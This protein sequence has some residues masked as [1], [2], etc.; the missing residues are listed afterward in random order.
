[1]THNQPSQRE[2]DL[3]A[4]AHRVLPGGNLGNP[5]SDLLIERGE[6]SRVWDV[7]GNEYIDYLLGS[8]PMIVGHSH[9]EV[10]A[11]VREQLE[12]G[13]TF[14]AGNEHAVALAEEIVRAV[15]CAEK[16]RFTS[17]GTEATLYAMRAARAFTGRDKILK[18]EGGFHGMNE[19]ALMS[20][21]PSDPPA[22]PQAAADSAGIPRSI[23]DEVLIAPFNDL[24]TTS[25]IIERH[26]DELGGVIVEPVQR[27]LPPKAGFLEG[28]REV[29]EHHRIPLIFDEIVTGFRMSYGGAQEYFGVTP[30][31]CTLGKAAAGGFP[32]AVVAGKDDIMSHMDPEAVSSDG[33]MPQVGTLSGNPI[34]AVA[35]LKTL[36][37]LR[38]EGTYE[39]LYITGQRTMDALQRLLDQAEIPARVMGNATFFDVYFTDSEVTDYR[40]I[41]QADGSKLAQFNAA[42]RSAGVIKGSPKFYVSTVHT[43]EDLSRTITAFE[44]V[45]ERLQ[46]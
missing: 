35:G 33:F 24:E 6:G 7:S 10:L 28:L 13:T 37:V 15:P 26:H 3:L 23:Q 5:G 30:D 11:V 29:T 44:T 21:A 34:A 38:R 16:V 40:S 20:M 14:F 42:L 43:E 9:P 32:L 1:M 27:V 22:F 19:Y 25:A 18:F 41:L 17:S 36:E 12:N 4:R 39:R 45:I 31:L 8:G 2:R 46:D